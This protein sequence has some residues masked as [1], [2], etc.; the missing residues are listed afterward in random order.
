M[1][2]NMGGLFTV[3]DYEIKLPG[4]GKPIYIIPFGDVHY[5]APGF[6]E[7]KWIEHI[8]QRKGC[9]HTYYLGMG[10][11]TDMLSGSERMNT[12][13]MH[14]STLDSMERQALGYLGEL[15]GT[16]EH[17]R[18]RILGFIQGNHDYPLSTGITGTMWLAQHF[19]APYLG[20]STMRRITLTNSNCYYNLDIFAHHGAGGGA[21]LKGGSI[22]RV[23]YMAEGA[24]ADIYL[25]GHDHHRMAVSDVR[26][27]LH[28]CSKHPI[29]V[30][31]RQVWY[32]R[33]GS[34]LRGYRPGERSYIVDTAKKAMDLGGIVFEIALFRPR[35]NGVR[36]LTCRIRAIT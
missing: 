15:A 3:G 22:N 5:G 7:D 35:A 17:A 23:Q 8:Q 28:K 32:C 1:S 27:A 36:T 6:D 26:L 2:L 14:D 31:E 4:F 10:D 29:T 20:C 12:K 11:Y 18:G 34:F 9:K 13:Y 24:E 19:K 30:R 25:M 16:L 21:R 33:T